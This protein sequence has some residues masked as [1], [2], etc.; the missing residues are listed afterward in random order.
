MVSLNSD[1]DFW[2]FESDSGFDF[3]NNDQE[4]SDA[5]LPRG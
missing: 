2:P 4:T 3:D 1:C 5:S